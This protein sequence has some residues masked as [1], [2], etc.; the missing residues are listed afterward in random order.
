MSVSQ[1]IG[2]RFPI[3]AF[4]CLS[5]DNFEKKEALTANTRIAQNNFFI[6]D[7][8]NTSYSQKNRKL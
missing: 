6:A 3:R 2:K 7:E 4:S 8:K 5:I 1:L